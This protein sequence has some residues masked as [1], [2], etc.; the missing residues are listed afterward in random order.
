MSSG[1]CCTRTSGVSRWTSVF[2]WVEDGVLVL[3][4]WQCVQGCPCSSVNTHVRVQSVTDTGAHVSPASTKHVLAR[5]ARSKFSIKSVDCAHFSSTATQ[6]TNKAPAVF[7]ART[8]G[9]NS[10][11]KNRSAHF[12]KPMSRSH[13]STQRTAWKNIVVKTG[14]R[15]AGVG[16][17]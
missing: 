4:L 10:E 12:S 1:I 3:V 5:T 17:A 14:R 11:T 9:V 6:D 2:F 16:V 13:S 15:A 7:K 8:A